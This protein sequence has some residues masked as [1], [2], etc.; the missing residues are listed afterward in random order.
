MWW[1]VAD[2]HERSAAVTAVLFLVG[3]LLLSAPGITFWGTVIFCAVAFFVLWFVF[4]LLDIAGDSIGPIG[5]SFQEE[6]QWRSIRYEW[7]MVE[8]DRDHAFTVQEEK[9]FQRREADY[10]ALVHSWTAPPIEKKVV[11]VKKKRKR[12]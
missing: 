1:E 5:A 7:E 6:A 11:K 10:D 8:I 12:K 3:L 2:P 9:R 4:F